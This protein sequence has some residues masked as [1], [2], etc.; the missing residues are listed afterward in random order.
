MY[1]VS[2]G[3]LVKFRWVRILRNGVERKMKLR[4]NTVPPLT[5][6]MTNDFHRTIS[7]LPTSPKL[8]RNIPNVPFLQRVCVDAHVCLDFGVERRT[9]LGPKINIIRFSGK[10]D[11]CPPTAGTA[12][13]LWSK[14]KVRGWLFT[15]CCSD[16][17]FSSEVAY[18]I[19]LI[20]SARERT[21]TFM[22]EE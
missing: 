20:S 2:L 1:D 19:L 10:F 7:S 5:E 17:Y 13:V 6:V 15:A 12:N 9:L 14:N 11:I 16:R 3:P 4:P 18:D 21:Y 8:Y 22:V